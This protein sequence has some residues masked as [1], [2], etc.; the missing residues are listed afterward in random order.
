M[1]FQRW[2]SAISIPAVS[3]YPTAEQNDG[4]GHDT[5][6]SWTAVAP[7]GVGI[8][9]RCQLSWVQFSASVSLVPARVARKPTAAQ[10]EGDAHDTPERNAALAAGGGAAGWLSHPAFR[11]HRAMRGAPSVPARLPAYPTAVHAAVDGHA[12]AARYAVG[13]APRMRPPGWSA[14]WSAQRIPFQRSARATVSPRRVLL[15]TAMHDRAVAHET[16]NRKLPVAGGA[17]GD[18]IA[19]RRPFQRSASG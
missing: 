10:S 11:V 18:P 4:D 1:P 9:S 14:G 3:K 7:T 17:G 16:P 12:T 19:Q 5:P 2:A 8:R 15:P 6:V 13:C